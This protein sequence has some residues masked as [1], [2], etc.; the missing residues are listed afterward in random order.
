MVTQL[1]K[2][3]ERFLESRLYCHCAC[4]AVE[5]DGEML[6]VKNSIVRGLKDLAIG[7][8]NT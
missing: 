7:N 4:L 5:L 8:A 2:R 3:H 1:S 6:K